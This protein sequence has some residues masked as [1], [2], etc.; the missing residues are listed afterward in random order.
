MMPQERGRRLSEFSQEDLA[1]VRAAAQTDFLATR[2]GLLA[3]LCDGSLQ[4][5]D[6]ESELEEEE[7][8]G[9]E[10]QGQEPEDDDNSLVVGG[11][12]I[13][14]GHGTPK[15]VAGAQELS[16]CP[17]IRKSLAQCLKM[18]LIF[19][20][21]HRDEEASG[22]TDFNK[23]SRDQLLQ[24]CR[25]L[26]LKPRMISELPQ[27]DLSKLREAALDRSTKKKNNRLGREEDI[28]RDD[29]ANGTDQPTPWREGVDPDTRFIF[30]YQGERWTSVRIVMQEVYGMSFEMLLSPADSEALREQ[31]LEDF[32]NNVMFVSTKQLRMGNMINLTNEQ[33]TAHI[34]AMNQA[35]SK[36]HYK[37][38][39]L[40]QYNSRIAEFLE[41]MYRKFNGGPVFPFF[42][43][44][45]IYAFLQQYIH[46][47]KLRTSILHAHNTRA[48]A[49]MVVNMRTALN[50]AANW[51]RNDMVWTFLVNSVFPLATFQFPFGHLPLSNKY[52]PA[53]GE[54]M[55]SLSAYCRREEGVKMNDSHLPHPTMLMQAGRLQRSDFEAL[56][57]GFMKD[58]NR[59][60][61]ACESSC[62]QAVQRKFCY[63][64]ICM[65]DVTVGDIQEDR[66]I[67]ETLVRSTKYL[68][69]LVRNGK[70]NEGGA[71]DS[72]VVMVTV[73][74]C[75]SVYK[76][77]LTFMNP[78]VTR[79]LASFDTK[80]CGQCI[81]YVYHTHTYSH[82]LTDTHTHENS[83]YTHVYTYIYTCIYNHTHICMYIHVCTYIHTCI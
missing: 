60:M 64:L 8:D 70:G 24:R 25:Q 62:T 76:S 21:R 51:E 32:R 6:G 3:D 75:T 35:N 53:S 12:D 20:L 19:L 23:M 71:N 74:S 63:N 14:A 28:L 58:D 66:D 52:S 33:F 50:Q 49:D 80:C 72:C 15:D 83:R 31:K 65:R 77:S 26:R 7:D 69:C 73:S 30:P 40:N 55:D 34:T 82:T 61:S 67:D 11:V 4:S 59:E 5:E 22:S 36:K 38:R 81:I 78:Q 1:K 39:T 57:I 47:G 54:R 16:E 37:L 45:H 79:N 46:R 48:T 18:E 44:D 68:Y 42:D 2:A 9:E 56:Q 27:E 13:V 17:T 10:G 29:N 43:A 41:F